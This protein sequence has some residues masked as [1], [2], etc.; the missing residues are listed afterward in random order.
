MTERKRKPTIATP[1]STVTGDAFCDI[2]PLP[3]VGDLVEIFATCFRSGLLSCADN[4]GGWFSPDLSL[5]KFA[6]VLEIGTDYPT[7]YIWSEYSYVK[8]LFPKSGRVGYLFGN[9][10][11]SMRTAQQ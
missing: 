11:T 10:W 4:S 6:V 9:W 3:A 7:G 8:V 5:E 1:A 2:E